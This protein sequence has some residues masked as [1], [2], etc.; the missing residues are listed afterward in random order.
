MGIDYVELN[1]IPQPVFPLEIGKD[2]DGWP[3]GDGGGANTTFVQ[4][5]GTNDLPGNPASPEVAQQADDDYYFAGVYTK[6]IIEDEW[7]EYDPV[8][9][10]PKNEEAAERAFAGI[11]NDLRYHFNLPATLDLTDEITISFDANN[12]H[13]GEDDPRYGIEIYF[14]DV[15]VQEEIVIRPD[16]LG[17]KFTTEPF[18][19]ASVNA[20]LGLSLIHI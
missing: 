18:T 3:E 17:N 16:D 10:V 14:N 13:E 1:P 8:G 19:L 5:T 9:I 4:E 7:G 2:D 12:L 6:T 11:D 15:M 20:E